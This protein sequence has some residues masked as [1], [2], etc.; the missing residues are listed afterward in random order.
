[1]AAKYICSSPTGLTKFR[2]FSF[3]KIA[4]VLL[5]TGSGAIPWLGAG[6]CGSKLGFKGKSELGV[7]NKAVICFKSLRET[8]IYSHQ[9][10]P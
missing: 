1:M 2:R 9:S 6:G 3:C 8:L 10:F 4:N 7:G 5:F